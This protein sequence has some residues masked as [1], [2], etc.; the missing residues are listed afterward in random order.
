M[1]RCENLSRLRGEVASSVRSAK[2]RVNSFLLLMGTAYT[3]GKR[4][5]GKFKTWA[6]K[7][8]FSQ[9]TDIYVFREKLSETYRLSARLADIEERLRAT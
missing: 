7:L 1:R 2:Q 8:E 3:D 5:T 6:E 4:W 9:E